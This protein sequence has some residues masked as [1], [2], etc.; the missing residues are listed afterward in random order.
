VPANGGLFRHAF[1]SPRLQA[2]QAADFEALSP[3][4]KF[5]FL[6]PKR[7]GANRFA[8]KLSL[9]RSDRVLERRM[10]SGL[11]QTEPLELKRPFG[12][13]IT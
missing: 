9:L 8:P 12:W 2:G 6:A 7:C 13:S 10:R 3:P 5:P 1:R 11:R 4:L